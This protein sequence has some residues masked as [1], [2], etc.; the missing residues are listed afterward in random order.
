M[1]WVMTSVLDRARNSTAAVPFRISVIVG[2]LEDVRGL[3]RRGRSHEQ[4]RQELLQPKVVFFLKVVAVE[5]PPHSLY[6]EKVQSW[7]K[8]LQALKLP[9]KL[10]NAHCCGLAAQFSCQ[11]SRFSISVLIQSSGTCQE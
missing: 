7:I 9:Q 4:S 11:P 3:G 8:E 6:V 2:S 5:K 10:L 1:S